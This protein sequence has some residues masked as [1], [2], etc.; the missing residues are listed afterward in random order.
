MLSNLFWNISKLRPASSIKV[1]S[2][3]VVP[4]TLHLYHQ[5]FIFIFH[6]LQIKFWKAE[7]GKIFIMTK[8]AQRSKPT[9][10]GEFCRYDGY[11]SSVHFT[12]LLLLWTS[13]KIKQLL[14]ENQYK[15]GQKCPG[16]CGP[17]I[18]LFGLYATAKHYV[19][20]QADWSRW[21]DGWR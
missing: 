8:A 17:K 14:N 7:C 5:S 21:E 11:W 9:Q 16:Q 12:Y 10:V 4:R 19:K 1:T 15:V 20:K 2:E 6:I 3:A 13:G 18:K